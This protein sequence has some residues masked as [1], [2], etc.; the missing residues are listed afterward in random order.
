LF[1][2][3]VYHYFCIEFDI[4]IHFHCNVCLVDHKYILAFWTVH[5]YNMSCFH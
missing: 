2:S 5:M 1:L 4:E 3:S